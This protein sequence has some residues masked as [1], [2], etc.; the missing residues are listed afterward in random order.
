MPYDIIEQDGKQCVCRT[1]ASGKPVKTLH[2]YADREAAVPYLHALYAVEEAKKAVDKNVGGGV[3]RDKLPAS[4]FVFPDTRTFPVVIAKDVEDAVSSWG[5]Y[6]GSHSFDEFKRRL[7]ALAKRLGFASALPKEWK[8][9]EEE[10]LLAAVKAIYDQ[11]TQNMWTGLSHNA[12]QDRIQDIIPL[13]LIEEDIATQKSLIEK[14]QIDQFGWGLWVDHSPTRVVGNCLMREV[15]PSGRSCFEMGELF[16]SSVKASTM[17][18]GYYYDQEDGEYKWVM[19][20]ERSALE[21][22]KA[23]NARTFFHI[24]RREMKSDAAIQAILQEMAEA[25]NG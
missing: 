14:G 10:L 9:S 8:K 18:I 7:T 17:S 22:T 15:I 16:D 20:Y 3:D 4:N 19:V 25:N 6:R 1:D 23:I 24:K 11:G 2:C 13:R 21:Q 5:R 12:W